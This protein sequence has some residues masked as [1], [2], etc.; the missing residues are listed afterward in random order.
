MTLEPQICETA[1]LLLVEGKIHKAYVVYNQLNTRKM[2]WGQ[3]NDKFGKTRLMV[4][5]EKK[6]E[7]FRKL[8]ESD[9][10][11]WRDP[12]AQDAWRPVRIN[13]VNDVFLGKSEK[14]YCF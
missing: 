14:M 2:R 3:R 12:A 7:N 9:Q 13:L 1:H 4:V 5:V 6:K 10:M 8:S 11:S